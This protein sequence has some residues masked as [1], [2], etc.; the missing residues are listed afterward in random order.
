MPVGLDLG[1]IQV[2]ADLDQV[3]DLLAPEPIVAGPRQRAKVGH[4]PHDTP[5][6]LLAHFAGQALQDRLAAL[7]VTPDQVPGAGEEAPVCAASLDEDATAP[8]MDHR[9]HDPTLAGGWLR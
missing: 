7:D 2:P 1:S 3:V 8:V 9:T 6:G 4:H 5:S